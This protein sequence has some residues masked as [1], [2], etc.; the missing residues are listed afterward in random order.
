[1]DYRDQ[2]PLLFIFPVIDQSD[3]QNVIDQGAALVSIKI[4]HQIRHS[5]YGYI[6]YRAHRIILTD[7][8][9]S[10]SSWW[11]EEVPH[12]NG[13]QLY[14]EVIEQFANGYTKQNRHEVVNKWMCM[15]YG[16]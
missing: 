14:S 3:P 11:E 4:S 8:S 1:M 5:L 13:R 16:F 2:S 6:P 12:Q 15:N 7:S 10:S 9:S